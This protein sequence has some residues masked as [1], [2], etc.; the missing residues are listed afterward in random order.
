MGASKKPD[1]R[2]H[3]TLLMAMIV[4]MYEQRIFSEVEGAAFGDSAVDGATG[5]LTSGGSSFQESFPE[6]VVRFVS[7]RSSIRRQAVDQL[8]STVAT[9]LYASAN[10]VRVRVFASLCGV[11]DK[12]NPP[13]KIKVFLHILENL[14]RCKMAASIGATGA[15][16][17]RLEEISTTAPLADVV[18]HNVGLTQ[19]VAQ[20]VISDLFRDNF[21][22]N[23]RFW[24]V[25]CTELR[26]DC[27]WPVGVC[28]ELQERA[29]TMAAPSR[30]ALLN[31]NRKIDGDAFL[32]LLLDAWTTRAKQLFA[33]L[34]S[35][36]DIEESAGNDLLRAR[37]VTQDA[38][39]QRR[40]TTDQERKLF[41]QLV[42]EY[43]NA[44]VP[45]LNAKV[46][47]RINALVPPRPLSQLQQLYATY[48][49]ELPPSQRLWEWSNW[50]WEVE[51]EWGT[52][53]LES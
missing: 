32:E 48:V 12:F 8:H 38:R 28:E 2:M 43:W 7:Q 22:W 20:Q 51:W 5:G 33:Q 16:T 27:S 23:F 9:A 18:F 46:Q 4:D 25:P 36:T 52:L 44:S 31:S 6:F 17:A 1:R 39:M 41:E 49:A 3:V 21:Y 26:V 15:D 24:L 53:V 50:R 30:N 40:P 37:Q 29:L 13:E 47:A 42:D 19:N 34:E 14:Y 35:A 45:W 11:D 10:N